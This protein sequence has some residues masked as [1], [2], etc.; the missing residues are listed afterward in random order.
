MGMAKKYTN[1][2]LQGYYKKMLWA[3]RESN[4]CIYSDKM[5]EITGLNKAQIGK[6]LQY[7]RRQFESGEMDI[8]N[9]I[10][11]S[12]AGYFLANRGKIIIAYAAQVYLDTR[13]RMRTNYGIYKYVM[14]HWP[15]QFIKLI[16]KKDDESDNKID[17][18]MEPWAVFKRIMEE[19]I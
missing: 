12:P 11:A 13:S 6:A 19:E 8:R 16:N 14:Q 17:D 4:S 10:M 9:Y 2:V 3:L 15:E 18:Q 7:G 1:E 5:M